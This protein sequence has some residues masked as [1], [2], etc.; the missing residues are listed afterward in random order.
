MKNNIVILVL[1]LVL[2][3]PVIIQA[4]DKAL[5]CNLCHSFIYREYYQRNDFF[6]GEICSKYRVYCDSKIVCNNCYRIMGSH[7]QKLFDKKM[8]KL[9]M[10]HNQEK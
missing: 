5:T 7:L 9:S 4:H 10:T 6:D 2:F 3:S 8:I 1:F